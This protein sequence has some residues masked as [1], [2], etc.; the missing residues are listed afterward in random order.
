MG[1]G[2]KSQD[3]QLE[4][5]QSHLADVTAALGQQQGAQSQQLFN[6]AFPGLQ[7][8]SN[9]EQALASGSPDLIAKVTAPAAQQV[10]EATAGAKKNILQ[11]APAGGERN[12]ALQEADVNQG[13]KIGQ[14]AS[15]GFLSAFPALAKL[16]GQGVGLG[17]SAAGTATSALSSASQDYGNIINE[18]IQQKGQTLGAI[19]AGVGDV[20]SMFSFGMGGHG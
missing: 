7:Q 4:A 20:T 5:S 2:G 19:G 13:A 12:L 3:P 15:S 1:G 9:F 18:N 17:Q 8:T 14:I 6:L 16:G 11:N 10:Q